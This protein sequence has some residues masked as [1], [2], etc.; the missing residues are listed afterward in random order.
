MKVSQICFR[1][2]EF[3][4]VGRENERE[5]ARV[6]DVFQLKQFKNSSL[7]IVRFSENRLGF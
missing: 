4:A 2:G 1:Q 5:V 3:R 7:L 6:V